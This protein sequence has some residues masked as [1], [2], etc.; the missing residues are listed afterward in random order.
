[1]EEIDVFLQVHHVGLALF[2]CFLASALPHLKQVGKREHF[3]LGRLA[4]ANIPAVVLPD[5][6][7]KC[8]GPHHGADADVPISEQ[9]SFQKRGSRNIASHRMLLRDGKGV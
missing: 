8:I 1:V 7:S 6:D 2:F 5:V 4:D 3:I 9:H